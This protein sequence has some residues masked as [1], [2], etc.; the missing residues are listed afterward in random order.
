MGENWWVWPTLWSAIWLPQLMIV[1]MAVV[2]WAVIQRVVG[3]PVRALDLLALVLVLAC[4][5]GIVLNVAEPV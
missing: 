3:K 5:P 2:A 1:A 4:L